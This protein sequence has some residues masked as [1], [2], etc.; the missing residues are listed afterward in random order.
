MIAFFPEAYPD[1]LLYS[2]ISR[3]HV[4]SGNYCNSF[5]MDDLY[6]KRTVHPDIEFLNR[7]TEDAL[8]WICGDADLQTVI[9]SQTM[10]PFYVRFL[11]KDRRLKGL[12]SLLAQESV[13]YNHL[14][15]PQT[16]ARY[17]LF[18]KENAVNVPL[19]FKKSV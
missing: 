16:G 19:Y 6:G 3:Y 10:F 17:H 11:P 14:G 8:K 13:F 15:L 1:E 9:M 2:R 5:T 7:F 12:S 18:K 4:R